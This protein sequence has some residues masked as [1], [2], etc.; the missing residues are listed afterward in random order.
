[1]GVESTG[2]THADQA[3]SPDRD[4]SLGFAFEPA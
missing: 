3:G 4:L 1:M 2:T